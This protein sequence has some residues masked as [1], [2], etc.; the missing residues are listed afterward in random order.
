MV[1]NPT[2]KLLKDTIKIAVF[3]ILK[4]HNSDTTIKLKK[5]CH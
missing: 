4:H 1:L 3:T 2:K 5:L